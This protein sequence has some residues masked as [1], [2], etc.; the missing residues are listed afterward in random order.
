MGWIFPRCLPGASQVAGDRSCARSNRARRGVEFIQTNKISLHGFALIYMN[1]SGLT[2]NHTNFIKFVLLCKRYYIFYNGFDKLLSTH[3][4]GPILGIHVGPMGLGPCPWP[5]GSGWPVGQVGWA[6]GRVEVG[7]VG[8]FGRV[9]WVGQSGRAYRVGWA[10]G[11]A[12]ELVGRAGGPVG[13]AEQ[14]RYLLYPVSPTY[15]AIN[16]FE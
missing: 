12:G 15:P 7:R 10:G 13:R 9:G 3:M 2:L 11:R 5:G 16:Q 8:R 6:G 1:L 4:F 14:V